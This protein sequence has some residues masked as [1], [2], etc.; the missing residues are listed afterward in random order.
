MK[1][2]ILRLGLLVLFVGLSSFVTL[3]LWIRSNVKANIEMARAKYNGTP[4]DVLIAFLLDES[5]KPVDRTHKAIWTLGQID[6][7][8]ALPILHNYYKNDPEGKS[9]YGKHYSLLCQYEIY[10]AIVAIEGNSLISFASL[11]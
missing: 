8:K 6:S 9:C 5:N 3:G 7:E 4:E 1:K 11:K 2:I 10:K